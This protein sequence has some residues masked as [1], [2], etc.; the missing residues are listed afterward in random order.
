MVSTVNAQNATTSLSTSIVLN[1]VAPVVTEDIDTE[2]EAVRNIA[3]MQEEVSPEAAPIA[4]VA[5]QGFSKVPNVI[6]DI[7][8][9]DEAVRNIA[10]MQEEISPE[11][12]DINVA[13]NYSASEKTNKY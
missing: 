3:M 6:E 8:T 4:S 13:G 11:A 10:M 9:E 5:L 12:A 1:H 7:D 2:E